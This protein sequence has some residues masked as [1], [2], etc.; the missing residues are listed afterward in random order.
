MDRLISWGEPPEEFKIA[1]NA[2][3]GRLGSI[4]G[5]DPED[6]EAEVVDLEEEEDWED[7]DAGKEKAAEIERKKK[8]LK[9]QL[10]R[11]AARERDPN[12]RTAARERDGCLLYTSPSPRDS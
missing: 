8:I 5:V 9:G 11:A 2:V 1:W 7:L 10:A 6:Q 4:G 12:Q 3:F